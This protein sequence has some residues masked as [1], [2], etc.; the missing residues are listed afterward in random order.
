[1]TA[2]I[3]KISELE[4][5]LFYT[6]PK[7]HKPENPGRPVISSIDD[8]SSKLSAD[9]INKT[10]DITISDKALVVTIDVSLH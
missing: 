4:I 8:Y 2:N 3:L 1:M 10:K 9:F 7:I 6:R 5:P